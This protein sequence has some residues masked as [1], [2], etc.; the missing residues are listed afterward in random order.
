MS[1]NDVHTYKRIFAE[2]RKTLRRIFSA[3]IPNQNRHL[4]KSATAKR[5]SFTRFFQTRR[6]QHSSR[7]GERENIINCHCIY[8]KPKPMSSVRSLSKLLSIGVFLSCVPSSTSSGRNIQ[9]IELTAKIPVAVSDMIATPLGDKIIIT[10]GC[11]EGNY[12]DVITGDFFCEGIT[13]AVSAFIPASG[14]FKTLAPMPRE[15]Y[16]HGAAVVNNKLYVIGGRDLADNLI[17]SVDVR[18]SMSFQN[19]IDC[20]K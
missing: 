19:N 1:E 6:I 4:Y 15:R 2:P 13:N 11:S 14:T 9:W 8:L 7:T 20:V 12:R 10:G 5:V 16:R 3:R 18:S 17:S